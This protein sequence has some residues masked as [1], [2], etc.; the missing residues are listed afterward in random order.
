MKTSRKLALVAVSTLLTVSL[1]AAQ[2]GFA[3]EPPVPP[4][5]PGAVRGEGQPLPA[6]Q[7]GSRAEGRDGPRGHQKPL[8]PSPMQHLEMFQAY[9]HFAVEYARFVA[10][11]STTGVASVL[12][13]GEILKPRGTET[14]ITYF[15][16]LLPEVKNEAVS[17]AIRLTLIDLYRKN[18]QTDKA[19]EELK[20]LMLQAGPETLPAPTAVSPGA[21]VLP[22]PQ[23]K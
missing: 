2:L 5:E 9:M 11:P 13:A 16:K 14:A 17:R 4:G 18:G 22:P 3:Q 21:P 15:T 19:L 6:G 1:G 10:S 12:I 23:A 8:P 20:T 7:P